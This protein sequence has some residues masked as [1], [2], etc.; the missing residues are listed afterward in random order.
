MRHLLAVLRDGDAVGA[1]T[2]LPGL[3]DLPQLA[4]TVADAGLAVDVRVEG[5]QRILP[6]GLDLAAYRILQEALTNVLR[7]SRATTSSVLV[8]YDDRALALRV[9]DPGPIRTDRSP[10]SRSGLIGMR[11]RV[12]LYGGDLQV[13]P[14]ADGGFAVEVRLPVP[15]LDA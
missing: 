9:R 12:A 5:S 4:A 14:T 3:A 8:R 13:G 1:L 7:H 10:G 11:E 6:R 15:E 2:P